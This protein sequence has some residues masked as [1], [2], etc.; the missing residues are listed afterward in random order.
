MSTMRDRLRPTVRRAIAVYYGV[1]TCPVR[2]RYR[3]VGQWGRLTRRLNYLIPAINRRADRL[4]RGPLTRLAIRLSE[5]RLR[6]GRPRTLW[7]CTPILTLPLKA[8]ADRALGFTSHSLVFTTYVITRDFDFNLR[9]ISGAVWRFV[10]ALIPTYERVL[11]GLLMLRYDVFHYF[12]DRG[13]MAPA[14]RFGINPDELDLLRAAGKRVYGYA[15]GADVRRRQRT[16]A[17]G[18]WNF[19]VECPKP[20]AFC[21][22]DDGPGEALMRAMCEKLTAAVALG[23]MLEYV[24]QSRHLAYWPIDP[25]RVPPAPPP[26]ADGPL[27][28]AHAPN[29]THFK[30][31]HYLE[32]AIETLRAEGHAIEY[33]KVQGVPNTE[34][35]RLF[36]E[37]DVVADQFIGGAYGYTAL[38]AMARGKPVLTYVRSP[39]LVKVADECPLLNATP[40]TLLTVLRWL[41]ANRERL[42]AIGARGIVY[43]RRWHSI[44][45]VAEELGRL[46][47]ATADFPEPVLKR[48][49]AQ[50]AAWTR[51]RD[52]IGGPDDWRHPFL[53]TNALRVTGLA[54]EIRAGAGV[55]GGA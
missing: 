38:E 3:L 22:C 36:G 39:D 47:E 14:T 5:R 54:R 37:A 15:Y 13:V 10:P 1:K 35:I 41:L 23:D 52:A 9:W 19:C 40:D 20:G 25:D 33:T 2:T 11:L 45:A 24:P 43:V 31:S 34:V 50:R 18:R 17:L 28:I 27:R 44:S 21:V 49:R 53:V 16:L 8:R 26:R 29:H 42:P 55:E 30:G 6:R 7:G 48:I 32:A 46:Y 4:A 12:F 51:T